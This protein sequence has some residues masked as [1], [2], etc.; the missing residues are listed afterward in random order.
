MLLESENI[1]YIK[2]SQTPE[3][4]CNINVIY[5]ISTGIFKLIISV[6]GLVDDRENSL[7]IIII[8]NNFLILLFTNIIILSII[9]NKV[10]MHQI[11]QLKSAKINV[12]LTRKFP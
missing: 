1:V 3:I 2:N 11:G 10:A 6:S 5:F 12:K 4:Q 7:I 9:Y 8:S